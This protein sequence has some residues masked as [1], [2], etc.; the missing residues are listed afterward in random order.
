MG[1][2]AYGINSQRIAALHSTRIKFLRWDLLFGAR[3]SFFSQSSTA[4]GLIWS[5]GLLPHFGFMWFF[6][7][8]R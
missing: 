1:L 3:E 2:S 5:S 4:S 8:D 6:S 7:Q